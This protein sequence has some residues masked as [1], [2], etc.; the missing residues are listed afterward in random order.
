MRLLAA[1]FRARG[2]SVC[3]SV[4]GRERRALRAGYNDKAQKQQGDAS[5]RK[6]VAGDANEEGDAENGVRFFLF[7]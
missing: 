4:A 5:T 1:A 6:M 2:C 3:E 7:A